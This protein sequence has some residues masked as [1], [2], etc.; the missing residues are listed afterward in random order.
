MSSP[1]IKEREHAYFSMRSIKHVSRHQQDWFSD[2]NDLVLNQNKVIGILRQEC[3]SESFSQFLISI[4]LDNMASLPS[5]DVKSHKN[6]YT[7]SGL[8]EDAI[9]NLQRWYSPDYLFIE[10]LS[11]SLSDKFF[12]SKNGLK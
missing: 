1:D 12:S 2:Y 7:D 6:N 9:Y 4:G 10:S 3:L 5:D 11:L 8:S